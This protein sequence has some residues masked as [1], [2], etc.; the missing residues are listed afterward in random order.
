M[1]FFSSL[2]LQIDKPGFHL[3]PLFPKRKAHE[4]EQMLTEFSKLFI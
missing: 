1:Y 4:G 3:G 2:I